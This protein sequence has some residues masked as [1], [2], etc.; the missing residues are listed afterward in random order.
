MEEE[1]SD[2]DSGAGA[3]GGGFGFLWQPELVSSTNEVPKG[4]A[5][6]PLVVTANLDRVSQ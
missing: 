1:D 2:E 6:I 3:V 5:E 4:M